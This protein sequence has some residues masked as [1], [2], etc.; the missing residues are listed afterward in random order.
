MRFNVELDCCH[1]EQSSTH[2]SC[3]AVGERSAVRG[4]DPSTPGSHA[5]CLQRHIMYVTRLVSSLLLVNYSS[6]MFGK[7]H[8][9]ALKKYSSHL[10]F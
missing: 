10:F 8:R 1:C 2:A 6:I 5:Q 3:K 9:Q 4:A 7:F